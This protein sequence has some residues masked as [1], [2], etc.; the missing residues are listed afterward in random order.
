MLGWGLVGR[1]VGAMRRGSSLLIALTGRHILP[2][3]ETEY[4]RSETS[5]KP[6]QPGFGRQGKERNTGYVQ[7]SRNKEQ[8]VTLFCQGKT[9][10]CGFVS[11]SHEG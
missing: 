11:K 1:I 6:A 8:L 5:P 10:L 9:H 3:R 2:E 7:Q 4:N